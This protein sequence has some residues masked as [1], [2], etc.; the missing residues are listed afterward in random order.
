MT[1]QDEITR[2]A[3]RLKDAFGAAADVMKASDS[4]VWGAAADVIT[5]G[6][7]LVRVRGSQDRSPLEVAGSVRPPPRA[8]R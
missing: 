8:S 2:T 4:H 3:D 6:D 1:S 7:T 5:S